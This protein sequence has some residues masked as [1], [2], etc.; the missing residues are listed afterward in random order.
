MIETEVR[1]GSPLRLEGGGGTQEAG[2]G[3]G[4]WS[5]RYRRLTLGLVLTVVGI[6]FE[7]LSV[8]T[9]M[10]ATV[11]DLGGLELYGWAFSAFML[12]MVVGLTV[13]G[14]EADRLGPVPLFAAGV[15]LFGLG[16]VVA[17]LAPSMPFLIA[18]R[19]V[20]GLGGGLVGSIV[21]VVIGLGYP[22]GARPRMMA[23]VSSA[24]ALPS[25]IGPALAGLIADHLGWRWVFLGLAPLLPLA[26]GLALP[27]MRRFGPTSRAPRD[28][29]RVVAALRLVGGMALLSGGLGSQEPRP[30]PLTVALIGAGAVLSAPAFPTL[31]SVGG[32]RAV[33]GLTAVLAVAVL[34]NMAFFGVDAFVPLAL[35]AVRGQTASFAGLALTGA[36]LCWTTSAWLQAH[37]VRRHQRRTLVGIG[38]LLILAGTAGTL[39]VL[40]PSVPVWL[41]VLTWGVAGFGMGFVSPTLALLALELAPQGQQGASS[42][43]VQLAG[44]FA[45]ALGTGIGGVLVGNGSA[46]SGVS[47]HSVA[48][49]TLL[50]MGALAI[51]LWLSPRLPLTPLPAPPAGASGRRGS[52]FGRDRGAPP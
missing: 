46:G 25:L 49:H 17:G 41:A 23:L 33:P 32:Q 22:E 44:V 4:V 35:S 51:A 39:A 9:T 20:Q 11:G 6:A 19:V 52:F 30:W 45:I 40:Q 47:P 26:A 48:T 8:A 36:T 42:S 5:R 2:Q 43:A 50:M 1:D 18:G 15:L 10:P 21:W 16:L 27:A 3:E 38:L 13:A 24:Y 7:S 29:G 31:V 28:W 37:L 34:Q 14:G 12:T